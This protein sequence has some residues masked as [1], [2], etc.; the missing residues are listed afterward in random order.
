MQH[1]TSTTFSPQECQDKLVAFCSWFNFQGYWS[2][3]FRFQSTH[4]LMINIG[5]SSLVN[6]SSC[7][8]FF[9]KALRDALN[10]TLYRFIAGSF[11]FL[12]SNERGGSLFPSLLMIPYFYLLFSPE[13]L[14]IDHLCHYYYLFAWKFLQ[15]THKG[16]SRSWL[17]IKKEEVHFHYNKVIWEFC[18]WGR[19]MDGKTFPSV[20]FE[21]GMSLGCQC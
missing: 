9:L 18:F 11:N 20:L 2:I 3:H 4:L 14:T 6:T 17:F 5:S 10:V 19:R 8:F 12:T 1:S 15:I 7:L 21:A 13:N 16:E